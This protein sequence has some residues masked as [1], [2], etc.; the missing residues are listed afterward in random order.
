MG[1]YFSLVRLLKEIQDIGIL[2]QQRIC[3]SCK[4]FK[5][6]PEGS[7]FYCTALH[8][9]AQMSEQRIDCAQFEEKIV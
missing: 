4:H 5:P 6:N 3:L 8:L 7:V 2:P 9:T 1:G